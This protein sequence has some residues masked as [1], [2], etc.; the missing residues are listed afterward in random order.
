[1]SSVQDIESAIQQLDDDAL[2]RLS[3]W[4]EEYLAEKWEARFAADVQAGRLEALGEAAD[5]AFERG[6]CRPL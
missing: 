3:F 4:F 1:M 2:G 5:H 6:D